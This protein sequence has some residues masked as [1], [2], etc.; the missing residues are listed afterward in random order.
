MSPPVEFFINKSGNVLHRPRTWIGLNLHR[1]AM[2]DTCVRDSTLEFGNLYVKSVGESPPPNCH[3]AFD[4]GSLSCQFKRQEDRNGLPVGRN[5]FSAK[6]SQFWCYSIFVTSTFKWEEELVTR[7]RLRELSND[8][9]LMSQQRSLLWDFGSV[10]RA[11]R[12][13]CFVSVCRL[14]GLVDGGHL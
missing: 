3:H 7:E 10:P 8:R 6:R 4:P 5:P 13:F 1:I 12:P 2:S 14:L 11:V 9:S